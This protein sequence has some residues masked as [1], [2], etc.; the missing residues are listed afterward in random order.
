MYIYIY[1]CILSEFI[2]LCITCISYIL[3]YYISCVSL[4]LPVIYTYI[5]IYN[6]YMF[7]SD[8]IRLTV[9]M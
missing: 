7:A 3:I 4:P 9:D 2:M 1:I 8:G 6:Y 5:Y